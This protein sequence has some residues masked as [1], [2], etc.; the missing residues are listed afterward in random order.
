MLDENIVCILD[1]TAKVTFLSI[2]V[3]QIYK[4]QEKNLAEGH[5]SLQHSTNQTLMVE[6]AFESHYSQS[7]MTF[8]PQETRFYM[9]C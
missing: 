9:I 2:K 1:Y 6:F 4:E 5:Q 8:C 3:C 7:H